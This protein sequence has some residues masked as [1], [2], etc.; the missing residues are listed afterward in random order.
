MRRIVSPRASLPVTAEWIEELSL[1]RY[2]PMM[3]LL[4]RRDLEFLR[5]Q[6]GYTPGLMTRLRAQRCQ[7]FRGYLR[8]LNQDFARVV[9]A[10]KLVLLHSQ[11]D[12]PE[13]AAALLRQQFLFA[14]GLGA[15]QVRLLLYRWGWCGV[16]VAGLVRIF[17]TMRLELQNLVP[18]ALGVES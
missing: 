5:E 10:L 8:C 3:R 7:I 14:A 13:L 18:A 15:A 6:P 9:L 11:D 16:D 1:E 2:R 17:D 4:D 12:R